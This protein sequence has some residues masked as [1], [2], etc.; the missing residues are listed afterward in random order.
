L[1]LSK[2]RRED[3]EV[4]GG[5]DDSR[6]GLRYASPIYL[7]GQVG[8]AKDNPVGTVMKLDRCASRGPARHQLAPELLLFCMGGEIFLTREAA[9]GDQTHPCRSPSGIVTCICRGG[10]RCKASGTW[11][12]QFP[13]LAPA[14]LPP[15][16]SIQPFATFC[17][18]FAA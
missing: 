10:R 16:E 14:H 11:E 4:D 1:I 9:L 12:M 5:D 2:G 7:S 13:E 15:E 17:Q 8:E 18:P 6:L 3:G